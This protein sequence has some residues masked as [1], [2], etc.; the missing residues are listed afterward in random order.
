[1]EVSGQLHVPAALSP[2]KGS[3]VAVG[4]RLGGPQSHFGRSGKEK[5][6][7]LLLEIEPRSSNPYT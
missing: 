5:N 2:G 1:M 4:T 7:H 3:P 6:S